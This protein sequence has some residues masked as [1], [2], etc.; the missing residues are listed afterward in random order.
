MSIPEDYLLMEYE[1]ESEEEQ[2]EPEMVLPRILAEKPEERHWNIES[3]YGL[4]STTAEGILGDKLRRIHRSTRTPEERFRDNL[5]K[6]KHIIDVSND[7]IISIE[8]LIPLIPDV[9]Y[10]NPLGMIY[11]FQVHQFIDKPKLS[12]KEEQ[13]WKKIKEEITAVRAKN[14]RID[15]FAVIRYGR[16]LKRI[17]ESTK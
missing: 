5:R 9:Q 4:T 14:Y 16:L 12:E 15:S 7:V 8:K 17:I 13:L 3:G 11:G 2:T 10:K 6:T 1:E